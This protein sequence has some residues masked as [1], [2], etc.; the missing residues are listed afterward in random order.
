MPRLPV[1]TAPRARSQAAL[2]ALVVG[3]GSMLLAYR[4]DATRQGEVDTAELLG[5][6]VRRL[7]QAG[8][9]AD[10]SDGAAGAYESLGSALEADHNRLLQVRRSVV[11]GD[12]PLPAMDAVI[13]DPPWLLKERI[14]GL[15]TDV[16]AAG[17]GDGDA[18]HRLAASPDGPT[19]AALQAALDAN[20]ESAGDWVAEHRLLLV[21]WL[22]VGFGLI[23]GE[24]LFIRR[25]RLARALRTVSSLEHQH[26]VLELNSGVDAL[27]GLLSRRR[28]L[29]VLHLEWRR[30]ARYR[31]A[32]SAL[33]VIIDVSPSKTADPVVLD[34]ML[35][36]LGRAVR[37]AALRPGDQCGRFGPTAVLA[38]LP[39]TDAAGA[40]LVAERIRAAVREAWVAQRWTVSVGALT[41][42]PVAGTLPDALLEGVRA[43]AQL[44]AQA[45]GDQIHAVEVATAK[46]RLVDRDDG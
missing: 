43:A 15:I 46:L 41:T 22:V 1:D 42:R 33:W 23:L 26:Q 44:A 17:A 3:I 9:L 38:I 7:E 8:R 39:D 36:G 12:W 20:R 13:H 11:A 28:V 29:E 14:A 5:R 35:P 4:V 6:Q 27:T 34:A 16:R 25:P 10:S 19:A 30:A 31:E 21:G 40:S 45:G 32:M 18:R 24:D 2:L 37:D